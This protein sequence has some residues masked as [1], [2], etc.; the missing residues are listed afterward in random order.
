MVLLHGLNSYNGFLSTALL[1]GKDMDF[2]GAKKHIVERLKSELAP[3]LYYHGLH[4]TLDVCRALEELAKKEKVTGDELVL[5]RTAAFYH[6][7]GFLEQYRDNEPV[8]VRFAEDTL[9]RFGYKPEQIAII[10]GI[11]MATRIPQ[12]PRTHLECVMCDA[13]LDYLGRNDFH[14]IAHTLQQ[15]LIKYGVIDSERQ[16]N[17]I[18]SRF[19]KQHTYFTRTAQASRESLK[20][21][22]LSEIQQLLVG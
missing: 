8:A 3:D 5:L 18:Q 21:K 16:W 14:R 20:Q 9:P 10:G 7:A 19:L 1:N 15:E 4:H 2:I 6:D 11:I 22:H 12:S 17:E 13:D